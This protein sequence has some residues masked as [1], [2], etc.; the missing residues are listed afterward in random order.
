MEPSSSL[1][2]DPQPDWAH[3]Q[4][5]E[6]FH[7]VMRVLHSALPP[8]ASGSK[9]ERVERDQAA[10][11]AVASLLPE[12]AFEG[13][14]AAQAV[15][16]DAWGLDCLR[17]AQE[18]YRE[19]D[20]AR[21][22]K[23]QASSMMREAKSALRELRRLQAAR[24]KR[25]KNEAASGRAAWTEHA[26]AG[27]MREALAEVSDG[28]VSGTE[29]GKGFS[30]EDVPANPLTPAV[31]PKAGE[32]GAVGRRRSGNLDRDHNTRHFRMTRKLRRMLDSGEGVGNGRVQD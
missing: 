26:V 15:A 9:A 28:D 16:A 23:A 5:R 27:M 14:L 10:L 30:E 29:T 25:D 19:F 11:A 1:P 21:K 18:R 24:E 32:R 8:L 4:P 6:V 20:I 13:R 3:A 31:S 17:L 22:C 7:E 2:T 12:T